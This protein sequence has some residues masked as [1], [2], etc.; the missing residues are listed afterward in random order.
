MPFLT[1]P[2]VLTERELGQLMCL[3]AACEIPVDDPRF[4]GVNLTLKEQERLR[5]K[6]RHAVWELDGERRRKGLPTLLDQTGVLEPA[7]EDR[8]AS[9]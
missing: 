4:Q 1:R 5:D 2:V 7:E 8:D 9:A 6:F 3:F